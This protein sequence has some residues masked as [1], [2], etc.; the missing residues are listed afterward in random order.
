M[1]GGGNSIAMLPQGRDKGHVD[2]VDLVI[3]SED[4][5]SMI[6]YRPYPWKEAAEKGLAKI[7][8]VLVNTLQSGTGNAKW[9]INHTKALI[10]AAENGH[11]DCIDILLKAGAEVNPPNLYISF[12]NE[13]TALTEAVKN[14][15]AKC[16]D[17]LVK[18]GANTEKGCSF[19][20][21][22]RYQTALFGAAYLK[23]TECVKVLL[24][25]GASTFNLLRNAIVEG[26]DESTKL[27]LEAG[28][29]V[30]ATGSDGESV[31]FPF[32]E[33]N[34]PFPFRALHG[35]KIMLREG[36]KVNVANSYGHT[37]LTLYLSNM[38]HYDGGFEMED[39]KEF[40]KLLFAAGDTYCSRLPEYLKPSADTCLMNICREVIRN[41]LLQMNDVNLFVRVPKLPLLQVMM[42]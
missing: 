35:M 42:S 32:F 1:Q 15:H 3:Q 19:L 14:N 30:N 29:D 16:V 22:H 4:F 38:H 8:E 6:W 11:V 33:L 10:D 13:T 17:A 26:S 37:A 40:A 34:I 25:G 27:L 5:M 28:A 24:K 20:N 41:Q 36:V 31:L 9:F 7:L 39:P 18:A 2:I 12:L 23:H 21:N